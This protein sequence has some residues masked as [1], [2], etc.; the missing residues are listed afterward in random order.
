MTKENR[1]KQLERLHWEAELRKM[2][3]VSNAYWHKILQG[4]IDEEMYEWQQDQLE[5]IGGY[6]KIFPIPKKVNDEKTLFT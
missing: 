5:N 4:E 6:T 2:Y 1:T 3:R